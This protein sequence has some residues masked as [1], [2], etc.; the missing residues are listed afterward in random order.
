MKTWI[1]AFVIAAVLEVPQV[2]FLE[3]SV[4]DLWK[5]NHL[6][7][8]VGWYHLLAIWFG[9]TALVISDPGTP[10][11]RPWPT[12]AS[13]VW[14]S[15]FAFQVLLTTPIIYGLLK[16]IGFVARRKQSTARP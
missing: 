11:P 13:V 10:R 4:A 12:G 7:N 3:R 6:L 9:L 5:S 2:V 16:W 8:A 14:F 15:V 1:K